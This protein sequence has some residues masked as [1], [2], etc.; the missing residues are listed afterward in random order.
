[1][2]YYGATENAVIHCWNNKENVCIRN[3][4]IGHYTQ[5]LILVLLKT[6]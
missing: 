1:M 4:G 2:E 3:E 5:S 6:I